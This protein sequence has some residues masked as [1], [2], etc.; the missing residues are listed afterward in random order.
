[1]KPKY[2]LISK[3][4]RIKYT[5]YKG[6]VIRLSKF[7]PYTVEEAV[8]G[9]NGKAIQKK[10]TTFRD[11]KG[12]ITE[13]VFD[14]PDRPL[15]NRL[16]ETAENSVGLDETVVSTTKRDYYLDRGAVDYY[17]F[18]MEFPERKRFVLWDNKCTTTDHVSYNIGEDEVIH[19]QVKIKNKSRSSNQ[20]HSFTEYPK[21]KYGV[22]EDTEPK[23]LSFDV[24]R[25]DNSVIEKSIFASDGSLI[26]KG[27]TY[28][29]FRA[30]PI[31]DS[32]LPFVNRYL[33]ECGMDDKDIKVVQ[34]YNPREM[35]DE[36]FNAIFD[37]ED[38]AIKFNQ[39]VKFYSKARLAN[40][41]RHESEHTRHYF[42]QALLNGG[43]TPWQTEMAQKFGEITD[44]K[45][46]KE[47]RNYDRSIKT[48]VHFYEDS[49]RYK[50]NYIE[51]KARQKGEEEQEKYDFQGIDIRKGFKHIPS[52]FL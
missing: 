34:E 36:G 48:Y 22:K 52:K 30:L 46:L 2:S 35:A 21:I 38:G 39:D 18:F 31:E 15:W 9:V 26:P 19:T 4:V 44:K 29:G 42:L 16:Y 11:S 3:P 50:R 13:R 27:D 12:N 43:G 17:K 14:Y 51:I 23:K 6:N 5:E 47:A 24:R 10:I 37:A 7:A 28:L 41:S 33:K 1:M 40:T 49:A 32:K 20:K 45:T 25:S 8:I